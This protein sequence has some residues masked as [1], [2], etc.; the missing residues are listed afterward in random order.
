MPLIEKAYAEWNETGRE[1]RDGT[2]TY[3]SLAAGW[4]QD[5]DAQ[6]L[7]SAATTYSPAADP[8]AE[9]AVIAALQNNEAVTAGIWLSGNATRFNQ[10]GLVSDHAYEVVG[11]NSDPASP[12]FGTFLLENPWGFASHGPVTWNDL[13]AYGD[14]VVADTAGTVPAAA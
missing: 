12:T 13:C 2:N 14:V 7:G 8:A 4:M 3:A 10:L 11:Y 5:V 1:G 6:V 9:Q